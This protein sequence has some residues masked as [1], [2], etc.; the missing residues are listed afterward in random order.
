MQAVPQLLYCLSDHRDALP[1]C[2]LQKQNSC[3]T[4]LGWDSVGQQ[5]PLI[6][7]PV[8]FT[9][10]YDSGAQGGL[11]Q[12]PIASTRSGNLLFYEEEEPIQ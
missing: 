4:V 3:P 12:A 9:T 7:L 5:K 6:N 1:R 11:H 2:M 10:L 8:L